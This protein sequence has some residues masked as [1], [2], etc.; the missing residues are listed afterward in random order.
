MFESVEENLAQNQ[1]KWSWKTQVFDDGK[2]KE[3]KKGRWSTLD[4][5]LER[6]PF[7]LA[8]RR[9]LA[10][11]HKIRYRVSLFLPLKFSI[12]LDYLIGFLMGSP[13]DDLSSTSTRITL[14]QSQDEWWVHGKCGRKKTIPNIMNCSRL[15]NLELT[16]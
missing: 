2:R 10:I 7:D 5:Y 9:H 8:F 3:R 4:H 12:T 6:W 16:L 1:E 11:F 13:L 15:I 14:W